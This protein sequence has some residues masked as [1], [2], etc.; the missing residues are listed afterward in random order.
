MQ[1]A[2]SSGLWPAR[3]RPGSRRAPT[4]CDTNLAII[5]KITSTCSSRDTRGLL[6]V[7]AQPLLSLPRATTRAR[8]NSP[9][10]PRAAP[11]AANVRL[12]ID[13]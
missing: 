6:L 8:G 2:L 13:R 3:G 4:A 5:P 1:L 9:Q 10:R 12:F 11:P 7:R